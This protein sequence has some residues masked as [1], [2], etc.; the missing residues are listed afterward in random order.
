MRIS[1]R[2]R[3]LMRTLSAY[4]ALPALALLA[5]APAHAAGESIPPPLPVP[6][7][8][9][10]ITVDGDLSDPG[11]KGAAVIETF[12]ETSPGNNVP[13]KVKTT[14]WVTYDSKY[15][16]IAVKCDDPN[17]VKI[18]APYVD[19]D[20]VLG[21]DDNVAVF[22]DTRND[23]RSA[24][25]LRVNPRGI[26]GD[27]MYNDANGNEDFSPDFFYDTAARITAEGW[28]AE[29]R[30][31]FSTLRYPKADPQSWG[32]IVWRNY[33]RDFRY[34]I[35]SSPI[36]RGG[37][38]LICQS[39]ELSGLTGLPS[40]SHLVA[41]PYFSLKE[42]GQL[43]DPGDFSSD[44][45]NAPA[46][47]DGGG[48]IKWTPSANLALDGTIN[49][50][51]SQVEAD[52]AQ[53]AVNARFALFYPEKRPFFL[54]GVDLFDTPIQAVYT[55]TITS[56]RWGVRATGKE[57][58]TTYTALVTE[59]RGGGS[60]IIPGP[61]GNDFAPQ[62]F[63]S[64][65]AIARVRHDL[66]GSFAG[67]LA[68]DRE[69]QGGGH[70]RVFGP[71]FQLRLNPKDQITGQA[72]VSLTQTPD[73]SDLSADWNGRSFSSR[74]FQVGWLHSTET[75]S[76]LA[77][78]KDFGDGFRADNGFVPQVG[79]RE[80]Q[81]QVSYSFYPKGLFSFVRPFIQGDWQLDT[82]GRVVTRRFF[83]AV[84]LMGRQNLNAELDLNVDAFRVRGKL[85]GR[86]NVSYFAQID[87]SR[88]FSRVGVT[89]F[90]GQDIDFANARVGNGGEFGLFAT[91]RP[92]DHLGLEVNT[93]LQWLNVTNE[94][95]LRGRLFTA[96]VE[97]LKATYNFSARSYARLIGQYVGATRNQALYTFA[98]PEKDG[99][100]SASAL[101]AYKLNWQTVFFLRC[102]SGVVLY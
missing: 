99:R 64:V 75:L 55:R 65:A 10:L 73:R 51:F 28:Q 58:A 25:E 85:L 49:P 69:V 23:R 101:F 2:I 97:R 63:K 98:V 59:D 20:N 46:K 74:A 14:A 11:W 41:A 7:A 87:P 21:T 5:A 27:A 91:V 15:F 83:P 9:G 47:P 62:D 40:A 67:F 102:E 42:T 70:N 24:V 93:D 90:V 88:R 94:A 79:F 78:Y 68:T 81:A 54:E 36:P 38:C 39:M 92:T 72:L 6:R 96:H 16:Y 89:G 33:P 82:E 13:P 43:R 52:T 50:D 3:L 80:G 32:I 61:L 4:A 22:L 26:Q 95:G 31:P 44:L 18:R 19:R 1:G 77:R 71:D 48:D 57:G 30:V 45:V 35:H 86:T 76:W 37:N 53:I 60:V 29:F 12:Y 17:P 84:A 56:P 100:F 66:G 34:F 8:A